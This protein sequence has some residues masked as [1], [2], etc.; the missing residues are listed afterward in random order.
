MNKKSHNPPSPAELIAAGDRAFDAGNYRIARQN[1]ITAI[2]SDPEASPP[3]LEKSAEL[4]RR[5]KHS[6][7][8]SFCTAYLDYHPLD[9]EAWKFKAA[10]CL[11]LDLPREAEICC[12]RAFQIN[13]EDIE[14]LLF[15]AYLEA[16]KFQQYD[17]AIECYD[18]ALKIQPRNP[19]TLRL[20][21]V[22]L[23][24]LQKFKEAI[25]SYNKA[26]KEDPNDPRI[27][28][29]K[30]D[31]YNCLALNRKA[32]SCYKKAV[33]LSPRDPALWHILALTL[34]DMDRRQEALEAYRQVI[35]LAGP[36]DRELIDHARLA[37]SE[38]APG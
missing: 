28:K 5:E 8:I 27:W 12:R 3:L 30:G 4:A 37:L 18:Q 29:D 33:D 15:I 31:S 13:P 20:K 1:Y 7:A 36:G 35:E 24:N 10:R 11:A 6:E 34:D 16:D 2:E 19:D 23:H 26:L 17:R 22:A 9:A 21:G 32:V 25:S 14:N 38:I